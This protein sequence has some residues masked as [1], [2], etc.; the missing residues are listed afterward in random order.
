MK[1]TVLTFVFA[2]LLLFGGF[3][4]VNA[5]DQPAPKKDT[6]NIDTD[7]KPEKFYAIEDEGSMGD[8]GESNSSTIIIIAAVVVVIG[9]AALLL[10][11]KKK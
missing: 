4:L 7:A 1:K 10:L 5:Q 3:S 9:G 6:V 11:R 8:N 2:F